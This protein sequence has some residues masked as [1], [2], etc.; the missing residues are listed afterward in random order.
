MSLVAIQVN[1]GLFS[2]RDTVLVKT[3]PV[4]NSEGKAPR[5]FARSPWRQITESEDVYGLLRPTL[6][7]AVDGSSASRSGM[8]G[9]FSRFSVHSSSD[10][11]RRP[12]KR[13]KEPGGGRGSKGVAL[14]LGR[15]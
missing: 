6:S 12:A 8:L 9:V 7:A 2:S 5:G 1:R 10:R 15:H 13:K 3:V 4:N 14:L 11:A